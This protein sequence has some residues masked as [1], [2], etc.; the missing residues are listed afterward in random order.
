MTRSFT[1]PLHNGCLFVRSSTSTAEHGNWNPSTESVDAASDSLLF[2]AQHAID[3]PVFVE[4]LESDPEELLEH[5][6]FDGTLVLQ[7]GVLVI[8][9]PDEDIVVHVRHLGPQVRVRLRGDDVQFGSS[10]V[11]V[12]LE[13]DHRS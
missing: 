5:L 3:G 12:I 6:I 2:S 7:D 8:H 4:V 1:T 13:D 9:D 11:Q 10:K